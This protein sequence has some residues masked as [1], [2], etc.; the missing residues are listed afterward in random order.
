[1]ART[2]KGP[3]NLDQKLAAEKLRT[4][5]QTKKSL[6]QQSCSDSSASYSSYSEVREVQ[7]VKEEPMVRI[8]AD[9]IEVLDSEDDNVEDSRPVIINSGPGTPEVSTTAESSS[10]EDDSKIAPRKDPTPKLTGKDKNDNS[11]KK[12]VPTR[13]ADTDSTDSDETGIGEVKV[14]PPKKK[15][16]NKRCAPGK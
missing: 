10:D 4:Q 2:K 7:G 15:P 11:A 3:R 16:N 9:L 8:P 1:M 6:S 14:A 13:R 5:L 12:P